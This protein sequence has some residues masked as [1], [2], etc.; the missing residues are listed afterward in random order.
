MGA[1][2]VGKVFER[3]TGCGIGM[4]C[5]LGVWQMFIPSIVNTNLENKKLT[6][7]SES[8]GEATFETDSKKIMFSACQKRFFSD[9]APRLL[10]IFYGNSPTFLRVRLFD[11]RQLHE[12]YPFVNFGRLYWNMVESWK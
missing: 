10:R 11:M 4:C 3:F 6:A 9:S 12:I 8:F 2:G 7:K 1:E 5:S